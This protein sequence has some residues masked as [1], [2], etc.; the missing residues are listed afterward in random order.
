MNDM[1]PQPVSDYVQPH[2]EPVERV[3]CGEGQRG[4]H[5]PFSLVSA[6]E[7]AAHAIRTRANAE[8]A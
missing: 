7:L 1:D 6:I 5:G 3:F 4:G 2:V 8:T